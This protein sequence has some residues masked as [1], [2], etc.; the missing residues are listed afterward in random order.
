MPT[1]YRAEPVYTTND[2]NDNNTYVH[3]KVTGE[4]K[5]KLMQLQNSVS[6]KDYNYPSFV[7][8]CTMYERFFPALTIK[9]WES[10]S[11]TFSNLSNTK[12][13]SDMEIYP[14]IVC[15]HVFLYNDKRI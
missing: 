14:F 15:C 7:H 8:I 1:F 13:F 11:I 10:M 9:A 3:L 6:F 2:D 5:I 4:T 12:N